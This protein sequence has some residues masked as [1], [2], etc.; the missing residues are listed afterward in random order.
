[1]PR[2]T[3]ISEKFFNRDDAGQTLSEFT[4]ALIAQESQNSDVGVK[5]TSP[6]DFVVN[7]QNVYQFLN[8][9]GTGRIYDGLKS[10][11]LMSRIIR[12]VS[13]AASSLF[14]ATI[15]AFTPDDMKNA[16]MAGAAD[17][18]IANLGLKE[19]YVYAKNQNSPE[20]AAFDVFVAR[21]ARQVKA[22][23]F[24]TEDHITEAL[25]RVK[26]LVKSAL[27]LKVKR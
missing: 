4:S 24:K 25:V 5:A 17:I 2:L 22:G 12:G 9:R 1:M 13:I 26:A 10:L 14:D 23:G 11:E 15:I 20:I 18:V 19:V 8:D 16:S 7:G 6:Q 27:T 3:E 21:I